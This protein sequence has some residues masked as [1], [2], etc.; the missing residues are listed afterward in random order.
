MGEEQHERRP[1]QPGSSGVKPVPGPRSR[2]QPVPK[3]P[4]APRLSFDGSPRGSGLPPRPSSAPTEPPPTPPQSTPPQ[5]EAQE[6]EVVVIVAAPE[7]IEHP[8]TQIER[9][10]EPLASIARFGRFDILGLVASGGMADLF[11]ARESTEG[12]S[13]SRHTVIKVVR[14]EHSESSEFAKM[15]LNEGRLA[16]RLTHP[17]I[18]TVYECGREM[19]RFFIAMEY[20]HGRTLRDILICAG[21]LKEKLAIPVILKVFSIIAEALEFAHRAR[22]VRGKPLHIVHRDVSPQNIMIRYDGVVKLLDFGVAKAAG[23]GHKTEAGALKGKFSYMSPEQATADPVD[24]RADIFSLGVVL[25][26]AISGRRLFHRKAQYDTLKA[27]LENDP[28]PLNTYRDD[29]PD[30]LDEILAKALE[31]DVD[32]RYPRAADLQHDLEKLLAKS[33]EVVATSRIAELMDQLFAGTAQ[34]TPTLDTGP[35]VTSR[36]QPLPEPIKPNRN[37]IPMAAVLLN[38]G[39]LAIGGTIWALSSDAPDP[40]GRTDPEVVSPQPSPEVPRVAIDSVADLDAGV[41]VAPP[42]PQEIVSNPIDEQSGHRRRRRDPRGTV[43]VT[44]PG[45]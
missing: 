42:E 11:L 41:S 15:F 22:D 43:I 35:G 39:V 45:F 20:I 9:G 28:P 4:P 3:I 30:G 1:D 25:F 19:G 33:G 13:A 16:M 40:T 32:D 18:C 6:G 17:N 8:A 44:D 29:I 34:A 31:K 21:D 36:F 10:A 27:I 38:V 7:P 2:T 37:W 14:G 12:E 24:S 5:E 23:S 26:E